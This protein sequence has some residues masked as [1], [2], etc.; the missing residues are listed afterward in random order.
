MHCYGSALATRRNRGNVL[1]A[2]VF[3]IAN[4]SAAIA[5]GVDGNRWLEASLKSRGFVLVPPAR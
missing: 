3:L 4:L 1:L 5:R 2:L